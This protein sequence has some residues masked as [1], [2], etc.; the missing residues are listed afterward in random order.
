MKTHQ[1]GDLQ[2]RRAVMSEREITKPLLA[3]FIDSSTAVNSGGDYISS[4]TYR[5][6]L[7]QT[8]AGP[9]MAHN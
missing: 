6:D 4:Y 2:Q 7:P 1:P 9:L 5:A 8:G 3:N